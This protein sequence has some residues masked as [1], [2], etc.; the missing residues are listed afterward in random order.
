MKL[1]GNEEEE[2]EEEGA[3]SLQ[4][5]IPTVNCAVVTKVTERPFSLH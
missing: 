2:E 1:D 5:Q 4:G 3:L